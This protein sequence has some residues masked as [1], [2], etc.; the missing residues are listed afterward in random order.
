M[1]SILNLRYLLALMVAMTVIASC[2]DDEEPAIVRGCTDSTAENYNADAVESDGSCVYSRDKFIG[3]YFG[4]IIFDNLNDL[5]QEGV[6]FTITPGLEDNEVNVIIV[7]QGA[8]LALP[9]VVDGNDVDVDYDEIIPD[10]G[11]F[12]SLLA[13][14][15]VGLKFLG[16]VSTTDN[17]Q[18]VMGALDVTVTGEFMGQ[19]ITVDDVGNITGEKIP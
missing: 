17:A 2:G 14:Q 7:I 5:N 6:E 18:N 12:N 16:T 8:S 3:K 1:K 10:G 11:I 15:E 4:S 13:G 19:P 9:G